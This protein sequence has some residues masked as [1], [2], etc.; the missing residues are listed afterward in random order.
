[1]PQ[2]A[3][4]HQG[5]ASAETIWTRNNI[6][7]RFS[8]RFLRCREHRQVSAIASELICGDLAI[9]NRGQFAPQ[10]FNWRAVLRCWTLEVDNADPRAPLQGGCEIVKEGV[11]LGYLVIH[12]HEECGIQRGSGQARVGWFAQ[13]DSDVCQ[14]QTFGSPGEFDEVIPRDVLGDDGAAWADE[15]REPDGVVA[16]ARTNV[17]DRHAWLQFETTGDLSGLIQA[18]AVLLAGAAGTDD[19]RNRSLPGGGRGCPDFL[20]LQE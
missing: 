5:S 10:E 3:G 15:R 13:G 4:L 7:G 17:T 18:I 16:T 1:M 9:A 8:T 2:G 11:G 6:A 20:P 12:V 19:W 14:F